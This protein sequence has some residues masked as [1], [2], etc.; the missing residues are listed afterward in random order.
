[1]FQGNSYLLYRYI[2]GDG[3]QEIANLV[4]PIAF[5][6]NSS[7]FEEHNSMNEPYSAVFLYENFD[8]LEL[9]TTFN[10]P[11]FIQRNIFKPRVNK[12][13]LLLLHDD[14]GGEFF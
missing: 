14:C 11:P 13:R 7:L 6:L 5:F 10:L 2:N 4:A 8:P 9:P 12:H 3:S 1:M